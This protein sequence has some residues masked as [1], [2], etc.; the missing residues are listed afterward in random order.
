MRF[1]ALI[2]EL[3]VRDLAQSLEFYVGLIGFSVAYDR[4]EE[5]F[6][7]LELGAAQLMLDAIG[8]GRTIG[9]EESALGGG[10]NFQLEVRDFDGI[11][12]RLAKAEWPLVLGP[13]ERRYRTPNGERG[14][15]QLWVRDPDGYLL[16]PFQ[17]I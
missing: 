4:P 7:F 16:R 12:A 13:E 17:P 10:I 3:G 6:A 2:P 14:Q 5:G 9:D 8:T 15:R 11:V 1:N